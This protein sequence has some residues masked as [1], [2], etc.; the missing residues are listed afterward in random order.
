MTKL[1][2]TGAGHGHQFLSTKKILAL[3]FLKKKKIKPIDPFPCPKMFLALFPSFIIVTTTH[4]PTFPFLLIPCLLRSNFLIL[5]LLLVDTN[6][7]RVYIVLFCS[8]QFFI[9]L[10]LSL[11]LSLYIY[12]YSF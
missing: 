6:T 1:G 8:F 10:N 2:R 11:S 3:Q 7:F 12:I 5:S 9:Y 4:S